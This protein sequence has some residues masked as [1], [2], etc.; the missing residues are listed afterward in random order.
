MRRVALCLLS[1]VVVSTIG[2]TPASAAKASFTVGWSKGTLTITDNDKGNVLG[3][4][5]AGNE[6]Q[7]NGE[8]LPGKSR[9]CDKVKKLVVKG[10]GGGDSIDVPNVDA[11]D[12]PLLTDVTLSGGKGN[13]YL[14]GTDHLGDTLKGG[15]GKDQLSGYGGDDTLVGGSGRDTHWISNFPGTLTVTDTQVIGGAGV[16]TDAMSGIEQVS[17]YGDTGFNTLLGASATIDLDISA[18]NGGSNLTGG[19][20]DDT[21]SGDSGND[22]LA[23][24]GG[25]DT[26]QGRTGTNSANGGPGTDE[27]YEPILDSNVTLTDFAVTGTG[28]NTSL[29][30]IETAHVVAYSPFVN[31]TVNASA[32][33]GDA[34]LGGA[35][36]ADTIIGG[37]GDDVLMPGF[38]TAD[39][40][41]DGN[42]GNDVA[43]VYSLG[44]ATVN[45]GTVVTAEN[46]T[47]TFTDIE[48]VTVDSNASDVTL[49]ASASSVPV[50]FLASSGGTGNTLIGSAFDDVIK[51]AETDD[52]LIGKAGD[53]F[54][55]GK[56]GTDDC[57]GG[58]GN[59]TIKNCE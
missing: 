28:I 56:A 55:N 46:G 27:I 37:S 16:G 8:A 54:L 59:D 2:L 23:G 49:D 25:D 5:C 33:T 44:N 12:Y 42:G 38:G 22:V 29:T 19:S 21:L 52:T 9:A 15:A 18:G 51:G 24:N 4:G 31:R 45:A 41:L 48:S 47:D 14:Y 40:D 35:S 34:V 7:I 6:V 43:Y 30:S 32:F 53:D 1:T 13:D 17:A 57:R 26:L 3:F 11:T 36:G 50:T 39:D 10:M 58:P 20:G